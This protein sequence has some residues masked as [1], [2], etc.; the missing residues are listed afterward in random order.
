MVYGPYVPEDQEARDDAEHGVVFM[1][2]N[3]S[4]FRQFEF[5]QQQWMEYGNDARQ[6]NDQD[7]LLGNHERGGKLM[8]QGTDDP[9]NPP[10]LCGG[11]PHFVE[12]RGGDYFF[13]PSITALRMIATNTVDPR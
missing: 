12:L 8:I 13:I 4:I 10:F 11:L 5:V 9:K 2:L 1:V 7:F 3:A 6:G